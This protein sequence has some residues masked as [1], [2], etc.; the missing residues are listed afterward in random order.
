[1]GFVPAG[2]VAGT[3]VVGTIEPVAEIRAPP[4]LDPSP[5]GLSM[6]IETTAD[7]LYFQASAGVMPAL[8]STLC[9]PHFA[10][11]T[12]DF[13]LRALHTPHPTFYTLHF[14]LHTP[15]STLYTPTSTLC[16]RDCS[17]VFYLT[18]FG[19]VGCILFFFEEKVRRQ[20]QPSW[21]AS[22]NPND[23]CWIAGYTILFC[24]VHH[25]KQD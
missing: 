9:A 16:T 2:F 21:Y 12:P 22:P 6:A 18:A 1:M 23:S 20:Y 17:K 5:P 19:F 10:L 14:A 8:R 24:V 15:H 7:N 4:E 25:T 13:A 3:P 11:C